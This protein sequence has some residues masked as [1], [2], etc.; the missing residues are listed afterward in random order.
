MRTYFVTALFQHVPIPDNAAQDPQSGKYEQLVE[1]W[2]LIFADGSLFVY[3]ESTDSIWEFW[4]AKKNTTTN[5]WSC[6][7]GGCI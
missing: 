7:W 2:L 3:Q 1:L 4:Q 6:S 5:A